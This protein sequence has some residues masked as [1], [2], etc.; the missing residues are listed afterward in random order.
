MTGAYTG[1]IVL[2][3]PRL[4]TFLAAAA[5]WAASSAPAFADVQV[6]IH[7]GLVTIVA[8]DATVRQIL[9]EWARVGQAKV[10]NL[11][12]IP[13]SPVTLELTNVPE[14][15]ALDL[16]LRSIS[17]Y[18]AAPRAVL[19]AN[20]SRYDRVV[21]MPTTAAP[22]P[23]ASPGPLPT[24]APVFQQ[25]QMPQA[26]IQDDDVDDDRAQAAVNGGVAAPSNRQVFQTFPQPQVVN[27]ALPPGGLPF[28]IPGINLPPQLQQPQQP[29]VQQPGVQQPTGY[30]TAPFGGVAVPGMIA[31]T[32]QQPTQP[33]MIY[34]P[35]QIPPQQPP[36]RPG[37]AQ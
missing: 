23:P 37:G 25:P 17:G 4:L 6:S 7:D 9:A 16:L 14:Q 31:P 28:Q 20:L 21:V 8:R 10:V 33:G 19:A 5:L 24:P 29:A 27:P 18:I 30:P 11:E 15:Q 22:R 36:R 12:R 26:A 32:P 2:K 13:G 1:S 3:A 35:G 34:P